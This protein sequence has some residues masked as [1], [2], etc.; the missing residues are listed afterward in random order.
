MKNCSPSFSNNILLYNPPYIDV[1]HDSLT[2][3]RNELHHNLSISQ[4]ITYTEMLSDKS[5]GQHDKLD[6]SLK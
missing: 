6:K 2:V 5:R 3:F 4:H 1:S